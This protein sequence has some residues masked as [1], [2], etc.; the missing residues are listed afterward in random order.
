MRWPL[1]A[2]ISAPAAPP[3][4]TKPAHGKSVKVVKSPA[5]RRYHCTQTGSAPTR[6]VVRT[7]GVTIAMLDAATA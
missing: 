4:K 3:A 6:L 7:S 1:D 2:A 5:G